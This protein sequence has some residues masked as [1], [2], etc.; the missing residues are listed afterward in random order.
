M[1]ATQTALMMD[2]AIA[3]AVEQFCATP[4]HI[5]WD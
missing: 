3:A 5:R 2:A 4:S 1:D